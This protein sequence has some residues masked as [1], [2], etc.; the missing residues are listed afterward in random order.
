MIF[1]NSKT[2]DVLKFTTLRVLPPV[3][4]FVGIVLTQFNYSHTEMIM[5]IGG[6]FI[7]MLGQILGISS[8]KYNNTQAEI[9]EEDEELIKERDEEDD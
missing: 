1:K 2:Y 3:L 9:L 7:T 5:I 8:D 4:T 6:A